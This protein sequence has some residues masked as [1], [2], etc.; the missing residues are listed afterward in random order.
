MGLERRVAL[1]QEFGSET[2]ADTA[3][4][5]PEIRRLPR[6]IASADPNH[7]VFPA[8]ASNGFSGGIRQEELGQWENKPSAQGCYNNVVVVFAKLNEL[9]KCYSSWSS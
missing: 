7:L 4:R 1:L 6:N 3:A 2:D 8:A 9:M 5:S